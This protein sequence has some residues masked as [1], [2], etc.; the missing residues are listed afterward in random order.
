MDNYSHPIIK[1]EAYKILK[2][3]KAHN[4]LFYYLIKNEGIE[5][6]IKFLQNSFDE[7]NFN[8]VK[9]MLVEY[10]NECKEDD[11][12]KLFIEEIVNDDEDY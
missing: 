8:D 4:E 9:K 11:E 3:L 12:N 6:A 10:L 2:L 5:N 7:S 1:V